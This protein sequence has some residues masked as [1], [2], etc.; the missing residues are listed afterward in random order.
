VFETM[1]TSLIAAFAAFAAAPAF[2]AD[3]NV[4]V[5]EAKLVQLKGPATEIVLGNPSIADVAVLSAR[6]IVVTGKSFGRTNLIVLD[7]NGKETM[8]ASVSVS[9]I[10]RGVVTLHKGNASVTYYCAPNCGSALT[11]GDSA[12]Y[13]G[14]VSNQVQTKQS[15]SRGAAD[16]GAAQ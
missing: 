2:A 8:N 11:V 4:T 1:R 14:A 16:G 9:E 7:A 6:Q 15:I 5:D 10:P 13:F 12:D 3:L